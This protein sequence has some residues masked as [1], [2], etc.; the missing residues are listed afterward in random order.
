MKM[1]ST[2]VTLFPK[3]ANYIQIDLPKVASDPDI[4]KA[5]FLIG[6]LNSATLKRAVTWNDGPDIKIVNKLG[7]MGDFS[8]GIGSN[9][10]RITKK[11]VQDFESGQDLFGTFLKGKV[12]RAVVT[13]LHELIHWGDDKNG[14]DRAGEEGE[15]F[16]R[17]VYGS[18]IGD[19]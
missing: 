19:W 9:E 11:L 4:V 1:Q 5:M 7:A 6:S 14:V 17:S 2:D 10:I 13:L 15:E 16:E 8:P 18:V 12:H 3:F